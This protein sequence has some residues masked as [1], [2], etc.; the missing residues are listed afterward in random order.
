MQTIEM[1]GNQKLSGYR[2]FLSKYWQHGETPTGLSATSPRSFLAVGLEFIPRFA[3]LLSLAVNASDSEM[4]YT[5]IQITDYHLE[6]FSYFY[7]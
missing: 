3:G 6:G 5:S 1:I 7:N 2:F 4:F